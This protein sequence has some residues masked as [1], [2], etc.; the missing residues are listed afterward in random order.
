MPRLFLKMAASRRVFSVQE[1]LNEICGDSDSNVESDVD[2]SSDTSYRTPRHSDVEDNMAISSDN[3]V[4]SDS[5][6]ETF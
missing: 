2:S 1:V 4:L 6:E 3:S 5:G